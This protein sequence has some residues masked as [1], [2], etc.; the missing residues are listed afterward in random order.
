MRLLL[1]L[2]VFASLHVTAQPTKFGVLVNGTMT[3]TDKIAIANSLGVNYVR[4]A[5][6]LEDWTGSSTAY[7]KFRAKFQVVL[8]LNWGHAGS[9]SVLFPTNLPVYA[10]KV[11]SV[12]TKYPD[13]AL[14]V[15]EN[16]ETQNSYHDGPMSDYIAMLDT[17]VDIVHGKGLKV[18]DGGI[19]PQGVCYWVYQDYLDRSLPD[20]ALW[21]KNETFSG[22]ML[23][24]LANPLA[25]INFYWRQID[26]LL[27]AFTTI[28]LDYV[29]LHIYEP[30]NGEGDGVNVTGN[31]IKIMDDYIFARTGKHCVT[32]ESGQHNLSDTL[33]TNMLTAFC[34][35]GY[36]FAIW[37]DG[38]GL[39]AQALNESN[40]TLRDNGIAFRTFVNRYN[41]DSTF[42][43]VGVDTTITDTVIDPG[44]D[45]IDTL[46]HTRK[47]S[48][49]IDADTLKVKGAT[50]LTGYGKNYRLGTPAKQL[51]VDTS[52]NIIEVDPGV[53]AIIQADWSVI[54]RL[55][56]PDDYVPDPDNPLATNDLFLVGLTPTGD[57]ADEANHLAKYLNP[58]WDFDTATVGQLLHNADSATDFKFNGFSWILQGL[59]NNVHKN[60]D[61]DNAPLRIGTL[62]NKM[63]RLMTNGIDRLRITAPGYL[64]I[65]KAP[66]TYSTGGFKALGMRLSD[67]TIVDITDSLAVGSGSGST[68]TTSLSNRINLKVNISDTAAML[69]PYLRKADTTAMLSPYL[70][71]ADTTSLSN[72]INLKVNISDTGTMLSPYMRGMLR[73]HDSVYAVYASG[74]VFKYI[75]STGS[76]ATDT[77]SL[78]NRI[79]L[80]VNISDTG[81][82]LLPY[83]RK[84]DTTAMLL[85]YLR[86]TDTTAML[87]PYMRGITRSHDSVYAVYASGNVFK[88]IDSTGSGFIQNQYASKQTAKAWIDSIKAESQVISNKYLVGTVTDPNI[89]P[90]LIFDSTRSKLGLYIRGDDK[91]GSYNRYLR[92]YADASDTN[93]FKIDTKS[94]TNSAKNLTITDGLTNNAGSLILSYGLVTIGRSAGNQ[95][96]VNS[97]LNAQSDVKS[98]NVLTFTG[99]TKGIRNDGAGG[100]L[101]G[102][103]WTFTGSDA[104]SS[105]TNVNGGDVTFSSGMGRGTGTSHF[106]IKTSPGTAATSVVNTAVTQMDIGPNSVV[107]SNNLSISKPITTTGSTPSNAAGTGAGTSPTISVTGN[108]VAG[109]VTIATGTSPT[110]GGDIVTITFSSAIT[111]TPKAI[112]ISAG[113]DNAAIETAKYYVD[114]ATL[115]TTSFVIKNTASALTASTT[116][117]I[118]YQVIQ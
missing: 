2:C 22:G 75:D 1:L 117:K 59:N 101:A 72:R 89:T 57:F 111:N 50:Q 11:N 71:K 112:I 115:G 17:A 13:P 52:G 32:N 114:I 24:G 3:T 20:S 99:A 78:S 67:S 107:I 106:I 15:I 70:R 103:A 90:G 84:T 56:D 55:N 61:S 94:T 108:D 105:G 47:Q 7:E 96:I 30:L 63:M 41:S 81:T 40:G 21:W 93:L 97:T 19:H 28:D 4:N 12:L 31:S 34:N 74:N 49:Y 98:G 42:C 60:G 25:S 118:F 8:N 58:G 85:P 83:L 79:N 66:P 23:G 39:P 36:A 109:Y 110:A 9:G 54:K 82:M 16:E 33:V 95:V 64:K 14:V 38:D 37:F 10:S 86:K 44:D 53:Q 46:P 65:M 87:A 5:I 80:K 69:L 104:G 43:G 88:Y 91:Q 92:I 68:D 77:T 100:A 73:S 18:T 27:N 26:T 48:Y 51:Y 35:A 113:N 116:Y 76:G 102:V 62:D 45:F 29:N 6:T